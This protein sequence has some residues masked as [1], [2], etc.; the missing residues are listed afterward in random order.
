MDTFLRLRWGGWG[1]SVYAWF[2]VAVDLWFIF[3]ALFRLPFVQLFCGWS[4]LVCG[5][6]ILCVSVLSAVEPPFDEINRV[7]Y[8]AAG[9]MILIAGWL[10]LFDKQVSAFRE[11]CQRRKA[12]G[13]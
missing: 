13:S 1:W 7:L 4:S 11:E 12:Q 9:V 2:H 6:G 10:L 3:Y 5:I 8:A